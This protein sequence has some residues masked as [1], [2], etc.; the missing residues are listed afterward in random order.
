[1]YLFR[2]FFQ[3]RFNWKVERLL[4]VI[5]VLFMQSCTPENK[6]DCSNFFNTHSASLQRPLTVVDTAPLV[7][8]S[9]FV[10]G[11]FIK[12]IILEN[13]TAFITGS[14][15]E[16]QPDKLISFNTLTSEPNWTMCQSTGVIAASETSLYLWGRDPGL[17]IAL[18]KESGL[19]D[20][21]VSVD[22]EFPIIDAIEITPLGL[23]IES[24]N[25]IGTRFHLLDE[26]T[27]EKQVTF[28]SNEEKQ[29]YWIKNGTTIF[30]NEN[31]MVQ[32]VGPIHWETYL[33][34]D[35]YSG[36][37]NT[38]LI[39]FDD[40]VF[41][42]KVHQ[43]NAQF[44]ALDKMSGEILW[45]SDANSVS[46]LSIMGDLVFIVS[47]SEETNEVRLLSFDVKSGET[48]TQATFFPAIL[49]FPGE[50]TTAIVSADS[51]QV[52]VYFSSTHQLFDFSIK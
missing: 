7:E 11:A 8:L 28:Q 23:L 1:M 32:A 50:N 37:E 29:D 3:N 20:W 5:V 47:N 19:V 14:F 33:D 46:N 40:F 18:D 21:Q 38:Q 16:T 6:I 10:E 43:N 4:L 34:F 45:E 27:G 25:P 49:K 42:S 35:S 24:R 30:L 48:I 41:V 44:A 31:N 2:R 15:S 39:I 51:N 52:L 22:K 26:K 12:D 17:V 36:D 13:G 9:G